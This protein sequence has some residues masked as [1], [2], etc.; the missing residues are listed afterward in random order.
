MHNI[1]VLLGVLFVTG[2]AI[3]IYVVVSMIRGKKQ[4]VVLFSPMVGTLI[5]EGVPVAG[6]KIERDLFWIYKKREID[7][8]YTKENG[9]FSFSIKS[10]IFR[11]SPLSHFSIS[12]KLTVFYK[13]KVTEIWRYSKSDVGAYTELDGI[14]INFRCE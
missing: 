1:L 6:V 2:S 11:V 7:C 13:N 10:D 12:Q 8:V 5:V 3:V 9:E 14:P 4:N